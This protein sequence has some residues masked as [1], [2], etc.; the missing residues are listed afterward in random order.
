MDD[1]KD[2]KDIEHIKVENDKM[3]MKIFGLDYE[4]L[5]P[6]HQDEN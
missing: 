6:K 2:E 1:D 5:F 3:I 4:K